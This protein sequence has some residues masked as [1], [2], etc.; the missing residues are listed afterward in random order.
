MQHILHQ[1]LKYYISL[2]NSLQWQTAQCIHVCR[3]Q[4]HH[5]VFLKRIFPYYCIIRVLT[6]NKTNTWRV[7]KRN[8]YFKKIIKDFLNSVNLKW[9]LQKLKVQLS[10]KLSNKQLCSINPEINGHSECQKSSHII[11]KHLKLKLNCI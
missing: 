3:A 6:S 2:L 5:S 10:L 1:G 7:Y 11:I 4:K 9:S 8:K